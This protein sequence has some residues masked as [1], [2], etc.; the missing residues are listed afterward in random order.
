MN[1]I[2]PMGQFVLAPPDEDVDEDFEDPELA[3]VDINIPFGWGE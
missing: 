3:C 2:Q 1:P